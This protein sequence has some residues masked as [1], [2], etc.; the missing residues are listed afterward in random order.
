MKVLE[1]AKTKY[2]FQVH[3]PGAGVGG[4]CLPVNSYQMLNLAKNVNG[5]LLKIVKVSRQINES[6]PEHVLS[7]LMD[8]FKEAGKK[9]ESSNILVLGVSYKPDVKD[10]Q[11]TPAEDVVKKLRKAKANVKIYDPYFKSDRVF[12][13][14]TESNF[15]DALANTDAVI[16]VTAHKEFHDLEPTFLKSKMRTPIVID[17]RGVIDQ[18]AA[19]KAGLIFRGLGRGQT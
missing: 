15:A 10:I 19:K 6:M 14:K 1:A 11:L 4:P 12:D 13:I 2:N 18:N 5:D 17:T 8:G 9:I 16:L 7:L 3:Y